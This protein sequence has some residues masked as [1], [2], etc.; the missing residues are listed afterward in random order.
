[1][2]PLFVDTG[3]WYA[4]ADRDDAHHAEASEFLA[5]SARPFLTTSYVL[6]ETVNLVN[7]RLG[8][9]CAARFIEQS[10]TSK[11]LTLHSISAREH[12]QSEAFF[13]RHADKDWSLTDCSSF[14]VMNALGLTD[15]FTFDRHFAQAGFSRVP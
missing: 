11:L 10:R 6:I 15:A 5:A 13:K 12:E 7:A 8:H 2:K 1:M 14:V 9:A 3:A 4:L